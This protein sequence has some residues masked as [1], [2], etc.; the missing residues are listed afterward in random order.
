MDYIIRSFFDLI[1][2]GCFASIY[3]LSYLEETSPRMD[4]RYEKY[5]YSGHKTFAGKFKYATFLNLVIP[6]LKISINMKRKQK[7]LFCSI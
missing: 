4:A 1:F 7:L 5:G 3:I 6:K 2:H